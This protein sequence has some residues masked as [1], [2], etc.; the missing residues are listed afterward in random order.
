MCSAADAPGI[1]IV[2]PRSCSDVTPTSAVCACGDSKVYASAC[3]AGL[4]G[5]GVS[6]LTSCHVSCLKNEDCARFSDYCALNP[7]SSASPGD[8]RPSTPICVDNICDCK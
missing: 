2:K 3:E 8:G 4:A 6:P 7:V 5:N 1:C